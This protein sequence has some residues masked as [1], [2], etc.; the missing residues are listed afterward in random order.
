MTGQD[1]KKRRAKLFREQSGLCHWCR[2]PMRMLHVEGGDQPPD[3]CTLDHLRDRFD[4]ARRQPANG[5]KRL[6]AACFKCNNDR[7]AKRQAE[8]SKRTLR[9]R[10]GRYP[11]ARGA[12]A[13]HS[14][15]ATT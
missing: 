15:G 7:G 13:P 4:P 2:Q 9:R 14:S 3:L 10:S 5:E 12:G 1:K 6:V 11:D 8:I